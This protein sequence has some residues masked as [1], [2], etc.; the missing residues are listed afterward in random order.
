M[1]H[2]AFRTTIDSDEIAH[3]ATLEQD[4]WNERGPL[5]ALHHLVPPRIEFIKSS[6]LNGL[7]RRDVRGLTC[8]DVGCGGGLLAEPLARLGADVTGIDASPQAIA[9]A[10]AHAQQSDLAVHYEESSIEDFK[11]KKRFDLVIASEIIEHVADPALFID[12]LCKKLADNGILVMTTLNRT[13]K[14]KILA[15]WMA[16]KV[17]RIAPTDLHDWNKFLKPSEIAEFLRKNGL[18]IKEIK[19]LRYNP[20]TG[21]ATMHASDFD[22]N[23]LIWAQK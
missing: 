1:T 22:I 8:L 16:Q 10:R 5:K 13:L 4:W 6:V 9:A 15:V 18:S 11:G 7:G 21:S 20:F 23:Y 14:S 12:H 3:F 19:G 17:L 2:D